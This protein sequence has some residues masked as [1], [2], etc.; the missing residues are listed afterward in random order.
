MTFVAPLHVLK[1]D[2]VVGLPLP[3]KDKPV[4]A[5]ALRHRC[6]ILVTGDQSHFGALYGKPLQGVTVHSPRSLAEKLTK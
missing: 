3:D 5:A 6:S 1:N 4:L 2:L